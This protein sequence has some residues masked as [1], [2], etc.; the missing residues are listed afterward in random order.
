MAEFLP[1]IAPKPVIMTKTD[2]IYF[3][4]VNAG[5]GQISSYIK[6]GN[7]DAIGNQIIYILS[8]PIGSREFEPT[9]GSQLPNLLW[10]PVDDT[11]AWLMRTATYEALS[12]WMPRIT[13]LIDQ[14]YYSPL[15]EGDG[16]EGGI[17]YKVKATGTI[18][19][20]N[21]KMPANR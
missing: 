21:V 7:L 9:F 5:Y 19:N 8:T 12:V 1:T 18:A 4:D 17:M 11:T 10:E 6:V 3:S 15:E 14:T 20:M 2:Q 13:L 16:Y